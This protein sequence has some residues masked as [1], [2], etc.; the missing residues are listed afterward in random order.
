MHQTQVM[1]FALQI[2]LIILFLNVS[3]ENIKSMKL[4]NVQENLFNFLF[5][6]IFSLTI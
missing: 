4:Q 2:L 5:L 1:T 6:Y 3:K